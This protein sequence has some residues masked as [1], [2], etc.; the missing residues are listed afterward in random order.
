MADQIPGAELAV[1]DGAGHLSNL[2]APGGVQRA[3]RGTTL[4][5]CVLAGGSR[6]HGSRPARRLAP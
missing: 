1:I 2:E 4:E 6:P 3:A 5:R